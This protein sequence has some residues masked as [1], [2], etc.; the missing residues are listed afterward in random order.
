MKTIHRVLVVLVLAGLISG[1]QSDIR[2]AVSFEKKGD[3]V[4]AQQILEK[5]LVKKP[6][7][8]RLANELGFVYSKRGFYGM[9]MKAYTSAVMIDPYYVEAFYNRGCLNYNMGNAIDAQN[10]YQKTI[11]LDKNFAKAYNNLGLVLALSLGKPDE[12]LPNYKKAI[13]LEPSNPTFHFNIAQLYKQMGK[14]DL[15][16]EEEERAKMLAKKYKR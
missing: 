14:A 8:P 4:S 1:C 5:A 6:D 9:A 3:W 12:A 7:D 16:K 11:S 13:E 10:D 15:A 2:K